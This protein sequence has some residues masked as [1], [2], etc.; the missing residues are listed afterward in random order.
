MAL[1]PGFIP[2]KTAVNAV[3]ATVRATQIVSVLMVYGLSITAYD[4]EVRLNQII[5]YANK[6]NH[7]PISG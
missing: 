7:I 6:K 4:E 3:T 1:A 5:G 2:V